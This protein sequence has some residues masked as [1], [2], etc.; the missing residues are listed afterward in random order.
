MAR[1]HI[2]F[3]G[4]SLDRSRP[5]HHIRKITARQGSGS[6]SPPDRR[7]FGWWWH[8]GLMS[9]FRRVTGCVNGRNSSH[10]ASGQNAGINGIGQK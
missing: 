7:G 9:M 4:S 2:H 3:L 1:R 10:S 6:W 5:R 8:I